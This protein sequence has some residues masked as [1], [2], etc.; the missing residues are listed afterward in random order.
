MILGFK[1]HVDGN[2]T[3]FV[4]KILAGQKIHTLREDPD[5]R[6]QVGM[7]IHFAT[8]V[9]TPE[10]KQ[11]YTGYV[12]AIEPVYMQSDC[13][14][15]CMTVGKRYFWRKDLQ[16][17][18]QNDGFDADYHFEN[19]FLPLIKAKEKKGLPGLKLRLIHWTDYRY[20]S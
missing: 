19:W 13:G 3:G 2:E 11:F 7:K 9:R 18:A 1:T 20:S 15:V 8:G 5:E 16:N 4:D 10:Y 12:T 6:W 17:F 14:C